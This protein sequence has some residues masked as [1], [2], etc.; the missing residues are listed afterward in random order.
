M[1]DQTSPMRVRDLGPEL[2]STISYRY[3]SRDP[4]AVENEIG[5]Y[6]DEYPVLRK[7]IVSAW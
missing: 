1:Q 2:F 4:A 7:S 3:E 6:L 5:S